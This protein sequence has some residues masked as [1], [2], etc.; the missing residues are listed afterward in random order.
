[1]APTDAPAISVCEVW[2]ISGLCFLMGASAIAAPRQTIAADDGCRANPP[3][4]GRHRSAHIGRIGRSGRCQ[5]VATGAASAG[6]MRGGLA[7]VVGMLYGLGMTEKELIDEIGR[8]LAAAAPAGSQVMLFGSRARGDCDEGSDYDVLVIEPEV[9]DSASESVRLREQ[10][11]DLR[12]PVDVVVFASDVAQRRAVVRGTV[13][14][15][16]LREG[17]VLVHPWAPRGSSAPAREGFRRPC[18]S[19]ATRW[20]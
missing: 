11:D 16:A 9:V 15:R 10:L 1:M 3:V 5:S 19:Q 8:R 6:A 13:V 12:A 7:S 2:P 17:R 14:D 4:S 18:S 20:R